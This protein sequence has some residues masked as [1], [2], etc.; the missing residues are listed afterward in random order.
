MVFSQ[1]EITEKFRILSSQLDDLIELQKDTVSVL[2][3]ID[4]N[5]AGLRGELKQELDF[6][7]K[8]FDIIGSKVNPDA[9][10]TDKK[11]TPP[12]APAI[13]EPEKPPEPVPEPTAEELEEERIRKQ[14]AEEKRKKEEEEKSQEENDET[15]STTSPK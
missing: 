14:M 1:K 12:P 5:I 3:T 2:A 11:A 13:K 10:E 8:T 9:Y 6:M 7:N 15:Q 4:Q